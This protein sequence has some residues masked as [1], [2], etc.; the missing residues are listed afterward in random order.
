MAGNAVAAPVGRFVVEGVL[1]S[2]VPSDVSARASG[3]QTDLFGQTGRAT[4]MAIPKNGISI[5]GDLQKVETRNDGPLATNLSD[6]IFGNSEARLSSKAARGLLSRLERS[7][8]GCP[9]DLHTALKP[10]SSWTPCASS[11][12]SSGDGQA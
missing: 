11:S 12:R 7:G 5:K 3:V 6:F 4:D 8:L 2:S 1:D 10:S 9:S